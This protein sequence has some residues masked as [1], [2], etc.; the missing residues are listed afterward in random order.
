MSFGA[1]PRDASQNDPR[2]I[3][4]RPRRRTPKTSSSPL[5]SIST[6]ALL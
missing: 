1:E 3:I 5:D 6:K 2:T 4:G